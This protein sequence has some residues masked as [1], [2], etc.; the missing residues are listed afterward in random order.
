MTRTLRTLPPDLWMQQVF[1]A[2]SARQ[3]GVVRRKLRDVELNVG[4]EQF[5]DEVRRRGYHAVRNG[6]QIVVFCNNEPIRLL[7]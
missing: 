1:E 7:V 2:K 5:C 6:A 4:L 3:G